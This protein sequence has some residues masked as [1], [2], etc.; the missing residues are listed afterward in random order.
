MLWLVICVGLYGVYCCGDCLFAFACWFVFF[1]AEDG[2]RDLVRSRGL[3]DVYKRQMLSFMVI[4]AFW[5]FSKLIYTKKQSLFLW[6]GYGIS[7]CLLYTSDAADDLLCVDIGGR[8]IIKKNKKE[9]NN[10]IYCIVQSTHTT[11]TTS[12]DG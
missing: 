6:L 10:M 11:V 1:Q 4:L 9:Q 8:R 12:Y 3:G 7:F 5:F 2:I